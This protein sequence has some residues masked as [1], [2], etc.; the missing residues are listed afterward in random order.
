MGCDTGNLSKEL[1]E[2]NRTECGVV[3][4]KA[5]VE[6]VQMHDGQNSELCVEG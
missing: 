4:S 3:V 5:A 2:M 6:L 1:F